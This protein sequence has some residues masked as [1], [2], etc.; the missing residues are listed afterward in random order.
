VIG[1]RT[2]AT[3]DPL[4]AEVS[5]RADRIGEIGAAVS[6]VAEQVELSHRRKPIRRQGVQLSPDSRRIGAPTPGVEAVD[7]SDVPAA[8]DPNTGG[9]QRCGRGVV[10]PH[11]P[12]LHAA[13][14]GGDERAEVFACER[15]CPV[16]MG[17]THAHAG[18][19]RDS[20]QVAGNRTGVTEV[21]DESLRVC[22]RHDAKCDCS[23]LRR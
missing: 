20:N 7:R 3:R 18:S 8:G 14:H 5:V 13:L 2:P 4:R 12:R 23:T 16:P 9:D 1:I 11:P 10:P 15:P 6:V 17:E 22:R 21:G 19:E